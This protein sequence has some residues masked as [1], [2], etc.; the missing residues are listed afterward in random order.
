VG[1]CESVD[2]DSERDRHGTL[3][4]QH[5]TAKERV[6]WVGERTLEGRARCV[7]TVG[8]S[9]SP[10]FYPDKRRH[11]PDGSSRRVGRFIVEVHGT[12][13]SMIPSNLKF[14]DSLM[15]L[16]AEAAVPIDRLNAIVRGVL[17]VK[18]W[19]G[20][21]NTTVTVRYDSGLFQAKEFEPAAGSIIN[22]GISS[23]PV[24]PLPPAAKLLLTGPNANAMRPLDGG[25][26]NT[27]WSHSWQGNR[28]E[29]HTSRCDTVLKAIRKVV[30]AP[31][32]VIFGHGVESNFS[33]DAKYWDDHKAVD[34]ADVAADSVNIDSVILMLGENWSA[35]YSGS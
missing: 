1:E 24:A 12:D 17:K 5:E 3:A 4:E 18:A 30:R 8:E 19:L 13:L 27:R 33:H 2:D 21:W 34:F 28:M 11:R 35:E 26:K 15:A 25:W 6:S 32:N 22:D 31:A 16:I 10:K 7:V 9:R 14:W 23:I 20:V 29:E